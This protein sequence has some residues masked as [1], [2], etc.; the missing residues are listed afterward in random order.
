MITFETKL[1]STPRGIESVAY[2]LT[3]YPRRQQNIFVFICCCFFVSGTELVTSSK[4]ELRKTNNRQRTKRKP[5]VLFSQAQVYEL[6]RRFKEQR[7]LSA[8]EREQMA[9]TLKLSS[10]QVK[11]W[12]QNRRYKNKRQYKI[13]NEQTQTDKHHYQNNQFTNNNQYQH[14]YCPNVQSN[15]NSPSPNGYEQKFW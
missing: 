4:T 3:T 2:A 9:Q 6:E 12:F 11:I 14:H 13:T 8:P 5:R 10:T 7:Y 15:Y 1:R